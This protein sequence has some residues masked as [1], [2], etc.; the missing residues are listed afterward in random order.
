M[1]DEPYYG[2]LCCPD[3]PWNDTCP[4]CNPQLAPGESD[5][6]LAA[7]E[8][9]C[10]Q[11]CSEAH[12]HWPGCLL[13]ISPHDP[14]EDEDLVAILDRYLAWWEV[15]QDGQGPWPTD[16][17]GGELR[18]VMALRDVLTETSHADVEALV[19]KKFTR[20]HDV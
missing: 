4:G 17:D 12:T 11:A 2:H 18:I 5:D 1:A 3:A 6:L 16:P 9:Q 19:R 13:W 8:P 15:S 7:F 14:A 10:T 20:G